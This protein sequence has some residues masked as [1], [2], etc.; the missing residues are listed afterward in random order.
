MY[1]M[2]KRNQISAIGESERKESEENVLCRIAENVL[3]SEELQLGDDR[4]TVDL[5]FIYLHAG[6]EQRQKR[7]PQLQP[8]DFDR[9]ALIEVIDHDVV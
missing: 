6:D 5:D 3:S 9:G 2:E 8:F 4:Q 1:E 7:V